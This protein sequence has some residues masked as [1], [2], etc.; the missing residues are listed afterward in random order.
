MEGLHI[1]IQRIKDQTQEKFLEV[2]RYYNI[3]FLEIFEDEAKKKI[4][5]MQIMVQQFRGKFEDA[6]SN[7]DIRQ[8]FKIEEVFLEMDTKIEDFTE[9]WIEVNNY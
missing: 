5:M 4:I 2:E 9:T 6:S 3:A 1:E 8:I 7:E